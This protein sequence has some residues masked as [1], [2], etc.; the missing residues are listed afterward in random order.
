MDEQQNDPAYTKDV[1]QNCNDLFKLETN[2]K[3]ENE[4][5]TFQ[6][7][8]NVNLLNNNNSNSSVTLS[9]TLKSD[10]LNSTTLKSP[11][12][13]KNNNLKNI[14]ND[15]PKSVQNDPSNNVT[16]T[17]ETHPKSLKGILKTSKTTED[18]SRSSKKSSGE[19]SVDE[20]HSR[21]AESQ[22]K[23]SELQNSL[24]TKLNSATIDAI[25]S[26]YSPIKNHLRQST[27]KTKF[28]INEAQNETNNLNAEETDE[29]NDS[30]ELESL[31]DEYPEKLDGYARFIKEFT[32]SE[33]NKKKKRSNS[34]RKISKL[35]GL[36]KKSEPKTDEKASTSCIEQPSTGYFN[37]NTRERHTFTNFSC[38]NY[39][40]E[41]TKHENYPISAWTTSPNS[42]FKEDEYSLPID[43]C[44]PKG[45]KEERANSNLPKQATQTIAEDYVCM[46]LQASTK[47]DYENNYFCE[48]TDNSQDRHVLIEPT[49]AVI[50]LNTERALPNPYH[51]NNNVIPESMILEPMYINVNNKKQE[52]YENWNDGTLEQNLNTQI[53]KQEKIFN[54]EYETKISNS[55]YET[56]FGH[57]RPQG[58][59]VTRSLSPEQ[60]L[61]MDV[62]LPIINSRK[63]LSPTQKSFNNE[64]CLKSTPKHDELDDIEVKS[65]KSPISKIKSNKKSKKLNRN[66]TI[67]EFSHQNLEIP[68]D[69]PEINLNNNTS[70]D[71]PKKQLY[72]NYPDV[73]LNQNLDTLHG[74]DARSHKTTVNQSNSRNES[75]I[76]TKFIDNSEYCQNLPSN[77]PNPNR[78]QNISQ[79][80]TP[81]ARDASSNDSR[82]G[83]KF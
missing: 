47:N 27:F 53:E 46:N 44:I 11:N 72:E 26:N 64:C 56:I 30:E 58:R 12:L 9:S 62:K 3:D 51:K 57:V 23:I 61:K 10:F 50:P 16:K 49:K 75:G 80:N 48:K 67:D 34:F 43:A 7:V 20:I 63:S 76:N 81:H 36:Q 40:K 60:R 35:F 42:Y 41:H 66:E 21:L 70:K 15:Q 4:K 69:Y 39:S 59:I 17:D 73:K 18:I 65:P 37:R 33:D 38:K 31:D 25:K 6:S 24:P 74:R 45:K 32:M 5:T 78:F 1:N 52:N 77:E 55:P 13:V 79:L 22:S 83:S 19:T 68:I 28:E 54:L 8:I 14:L 71:S 29:T 2:E 82:N